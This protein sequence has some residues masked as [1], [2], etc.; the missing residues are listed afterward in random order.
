[1]TYRN[2]SYLKIN[3]TDFIL[4]CLFNPRI[5]FTPALE[6]LLSHKNRKKI[7]ITKQNAIFLNLVFIQYK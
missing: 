7:L 3:Q 2:T 4:V 1:M 6:L 5:D